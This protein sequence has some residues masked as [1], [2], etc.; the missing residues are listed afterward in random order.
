MASTETM[1]ELYT[2]C[3]ARLA[4]KFDPS[5]P[6]S[7]NIPS[8]DESHKGLYL[9]LLSSS[10]K[11]L[12]SSGFLQDNQ[13]NVNLS[14]DRVIESFFAELRGKG[15]SYNQIE[16][17]T[18]FLYLVKEVEYLPRPTEWDENKDGVY[19]MWGQEFR[20]LYLPY[21]IK[22]LAC[23]KMEVLDRLLSWNIGIIS[24]LWKL[25]EGLCFALK[26]ESYP[27]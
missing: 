6:V 23:S 21:Q 13:S 3:K 7:I 16:T 26:M 4:Q 17:G 25:P 1:N 12:A 2:Y 5:L 14:L 27:D 11:D 24:N 19:F 9:G 18:L 10:N 22:Q 15:I 8:F 20:G